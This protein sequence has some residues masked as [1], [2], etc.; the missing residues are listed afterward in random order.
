M[1]GGGGAHLPQMPMLDPP[2][3]PYEKLYC[4]DSQDPTIAIKTRTDSP[5]C[6]SVYLYCCVF[7]VC[8]VHSFQFY[9]DSMYY[10]WLRV[11]AVNS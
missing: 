6:I 1:G 11:H 10:F 2:M 5:A 8:I 9:K 3:Q 7:S 4:C